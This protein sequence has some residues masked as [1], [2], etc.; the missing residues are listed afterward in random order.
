MF[1]ADAGFE[2]K[3]SWVI[4]YVPCILLDSILNWQFVCFSHNI[5]IE[6]SFKRFPCLFCLQM[7]LTWKIYNLL[8]LWLTYFSLFKII[9]LIFLLFSKKTVKH[10]F[11][12][13]LF[14]S[15]KG[16]ILVYYTF[17]WMYNFFFLSNFPLLMKVFLSFKAYTQSFVEW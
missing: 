1:A 12:L 10:F 9:Y 15:K 5:T 13:V 17:L 16:F 11:L 6:H 14:H 3:S 4:P 7:V 8:L 2:Q